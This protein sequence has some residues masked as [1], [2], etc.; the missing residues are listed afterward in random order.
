MGRIT[1]DGHANISG[2]GDSCAGGLANVNVEVLT[3]ANGDTLTVTSDDVA[4]PTGPGQYH[5]TGQW[6][7]TGGTGR[8][9][10]T[11]GFGSLNGSL[12]FNT[13]TFTV[14]L[15]GSISMESQ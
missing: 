9:S 10:D 12:D 5:G 15:T 7:V 8:F 3:A 13:G 14:D 1:S 11:T 6:Q 4:C 2:S